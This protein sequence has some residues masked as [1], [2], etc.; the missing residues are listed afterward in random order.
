MW[1]VWYETG[2]SARGLRGNDQ[3][4]AARIVADPAAP[5]GFHWQAEGNGTAGQVNPLDTSGSGFGPCAASVA[6]EDACSLNRNPAAGAE[7]PR[8][9]TGTL[10]PGSATVPWVVWSEDVGGRH[11]VFVSRLVG[12]NHFE[13]FN[14]GNPVSHAGRDAASPDIAFF[15]NVP[16]ISWIETVGSAKVGFVGH[17][18]GAAFVS[19]TPAGIRL[20][21]PRGSVSLI[22]FRV[23]VS[24]SC[25]A[26]P[27]TSDG[28]ACP[29]GAP[30]APFITFTRTGSPQALFAEAVGPC[31]LLSGCTCSVRVSGDHAVVGAT[32]GQSAPVG[33]LVQRI[34]RERR[35]RGRVVRTLH[36]VGRVPFGLQRRGAVRVRWNLKVHGR[37]LPPGRYLVTLRGF[38]AGH[39]IVARATPVVVAIR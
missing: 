8:V 18:E 11:A 21:S 23:P 7:D 22:D 29:G 30:D 9:A 37:R 33:I 35:V 24:S 26:D 14:G 32:L 28:S 5:G 10:T 6:A 2:P 27:F 31:S 13:L 36:T 38:G 19:D 4:F 39:A 16:Y 34:V 3:V 17:F 1:T 15:G 25:T 12:G 20:P